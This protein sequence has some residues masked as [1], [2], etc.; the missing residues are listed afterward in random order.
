MI[1]QTRADPRM[2]ILVLPGGWWDSHWMDATG[3][4]PR[5]HAR[6]Q[7]VTGWHG[8]PLREADCRGRVA[9]RQRLGA[10]SC[11]ADRHAPVSP[12][13]LTASIALY[14]RPLTHASF[15]LDW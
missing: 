6:T 3:A 14:V 15:A 1:R 8:A 2:V 10:S 4:A 5:G 13:S 11:P 7:P 9:A 12:A